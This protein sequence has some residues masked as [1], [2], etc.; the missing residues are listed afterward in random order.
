MTHRELGQRAGTG[1]QVSWLPVSG[2]RTADEY[3]LFSTSLDLLKFFLDTGA[4]ASDG[5]SE[6]SCVWPML[7]LQFGELVLHV[8]IQKISHKHADFELLLEMQTLVKLVLHSHR[9]WSGLTL[10]SFRLDTGA[11]PG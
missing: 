6:L 9:C 5:A 11:P 1:T 8:K 10:V 4:Q 7:C 3:S 2:S